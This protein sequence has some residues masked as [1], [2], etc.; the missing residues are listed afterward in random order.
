MGIILNVV[1]KENKEQEDNLN[2][3][4]NPKNEEEL[5]KYWYYQIYELRLGWTEKL[6]L[7]N[8]PALSAECI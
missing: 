4:Y 2:K 6:A 7:I 1:Y 5:K 3:K 8:F